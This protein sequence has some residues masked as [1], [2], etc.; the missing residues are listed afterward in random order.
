MLRLVLKRLVLGF[1][2]GETQRSLQQEKLKDDLKARPSAVVLAVVV[3]AGYSI[4]LNT[5]IP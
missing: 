2:I 5:V 4:I 3:L 1:R